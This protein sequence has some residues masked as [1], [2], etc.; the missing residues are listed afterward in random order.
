[1]YVFHHQH[2]T[3]YKFYVFKTLMIKLDENLTLHLILG[4]DGETYIVP[5]LYDGDCM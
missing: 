2:S 3:N 5:I 4:G 1:M